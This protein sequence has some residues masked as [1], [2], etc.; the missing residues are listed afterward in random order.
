MEPG[1]F[2][3]A[4]SADSECWKAGLCNEKERKKAIPK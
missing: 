4:S 2:S 1:N 3:Q